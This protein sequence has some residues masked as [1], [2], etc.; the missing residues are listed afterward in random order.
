MLRFALRRSAQALLTI[1]AATFVV[2]TMLYVLPGD[3]IR[4]LFGFRPPPPQVLEEL[5]RSYG[6]DQ[7]YAV[8]YVRYLGRLVQGDLGRSF[9]G[10]PVEA[11][12]VPAIPRTLALLGGTVV[13]EAAIASLVGLASLTGLGGRRD[14]L[15]HLGGLLVASIPVV[16][17]A[18]LMQAILAGWLGLLPLTARNSD[19]GDPAGFLLPVLAMAAWFG[20]VLLRQL[21]ADVGRTVHEPYIRTAHAKGLSPGRVNAVH[22]LRPAAGPTLNLAGAQVGELLGALIIIEG[23]FHVGGVGSVIYTALENRDQAVILGGVTA[24]L[25]AVIVATALV[26]IASAA[27]DPRLRAARD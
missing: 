11:L 25:I 9:F 4:A 14:R 8:Q 15:A 10:R 6:L 18:F 7:S 20:A 16:V 22:A 12:L 19:M 23:V 17:V 1:L 13:L 27:L 2:F 3:P 21:R 5:K 26:D 24:M